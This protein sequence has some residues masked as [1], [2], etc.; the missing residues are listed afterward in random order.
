MALRLSVEF[1][2]EWQLFAIHHRTQL[3]AK[4]LCRDF[5]FVVYITDKILVPNGV[6]YRG[7]PPTVERRRSKEM[8]PKLAVGCM[9][10]LSNEGRGNGALPR[11][12]HCCSGLSPCAT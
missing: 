6:R 10:S 4:V 7:V 5:H 1:C 2:G 12:A 9:A 11:R 8:L 3:S